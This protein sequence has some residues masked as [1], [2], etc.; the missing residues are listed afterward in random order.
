MKTNIFI[1]SVLFLSFSFVMLDADVE[2]GEEIRIRNYVLNDRD[3]SSGTPDR[4]SYWEQR[5]LL[6]LGFRLNK[7]LSARLET[8]AKG[9]FGENP[10]GDLWFSESWLRFEKK[11][12]F[13]AELKIGRQYYQ[14]GDG[15][16][17]SHND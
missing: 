1:F 16:L 2:I 17:L 4:I 5:T 6:Y 14:L 15:V 11:I 8:A 13:P 3:F 12:L 10:A 9:R 7:E